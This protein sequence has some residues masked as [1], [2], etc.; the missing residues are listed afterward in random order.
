M[1]TLFVLYGQPADTAEFDRYFT[2]VHL[3][4]ADKIPGVRRL[5]YGHVQSI[6]GAAPPYYLSA[7]VVFDSLDDLRA[8]MGSP[9]GQAA[10]AD[11]ATFATGGATNLIQL[12]ER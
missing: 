5:S 10:A 4:L 3:P 8:G 2:D 1:A 12:D 7:Q 11:V 6:D 9:E